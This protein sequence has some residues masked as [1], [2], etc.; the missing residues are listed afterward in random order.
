MKNEDLKNYNDARERRKGFVRRRLL[1]QPRTEARKRSALWLPVLQACLAR[2]PSLLS[3]EILRVRPPS[4]I[5]VLLPSG[6]QL[7]FPPRQRAPYRPLR[8]PN[9]TRPQLQVLPS[10]PPYRVRRQSV[11][12]PL[13]MECRSISFVFKPPLP[14]HRLL[15]RARNVRP[16]AKVGRVGSRYRTMRRTLRSASSSTILCP[17]SRRSGCVVAVNSKAM[18]PLWFERPC[19]RFDAMFVPSKIGRAH[20]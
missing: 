18:P 17:L 11:H 16:P 19:R 2:P 7:A 4:S 13:T 8:H 12:T 10:P 14:R 9:L 15:N 20:V 3:L 6:D 5:P 1:V